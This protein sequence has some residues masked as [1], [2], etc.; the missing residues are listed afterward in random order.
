MR[1]CIPRCRCTS[2]GRFS[3]PARR[4][5]PTTGTRCSF[6][7]APC[8]RRY[9]STSTAAVLE[10][11]V[12]HWQ[13]PV[14]EPA[15]AAAFTGVRHRSA[16]GCAARRQDRRPAPLPRRVRRDAR[17]LAARPR[18]DVE[19]LSL[20]PRRNVHTCRRRGAARRGRA[21]DVS[22]VP[23]PAMGAVVVHRGTV[24]RVVSIWHGCR[25]GP[26]A[27]G[28]EQRPL[29]SRDGSR[30]A[31]YLRRHCRLVQAGL[32]SAGDGGVRRSA[33]GTSGGAETAPGAALRRRPPQSRHPRV[34]RP[35]PDEPADVGDLVP[36]AVSVPCVWAA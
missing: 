31:R 9:S 17:A 3:A 32:A 20:V 1:P 4:S 29:H 11:L 25:R 24:E 30:C 6:S 15:N 26:C 10:S 35:R 14:A 16:G 28:L 34:R 33:H 21:P 12:N 18:G 5:A 23:L 19:S 8:S 27:G 2:S 36:R 13:R 7:T 22:S